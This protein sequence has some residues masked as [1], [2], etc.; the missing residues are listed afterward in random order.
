MPSTS[1]SFFS[2][3]FFPLNSIFTG[4]RRARGS[5]PDEVALIRAAA[6]AWYQ[7]GSGSQGINKP[8]TREYDITRT[9]RVY[10][11]SRYRIEAI[12]RM[13]MAKEE[14]QHQHQHQ[15]AVV[16]PDPE[17][18]MS[19][20]GPQ[21]LA[22]SDPVHAANSLLDS[23]RVQ[24]TASDTTSDYFQSSFVVD[25]GGHHHRQRN[26]CS[27]PSSSSLSSPES[28]TSSN[29]NSMSIK[30][31]E[32]RSIGLWLWRRRAVICGRSEDVVVDNSTVFRRSAHGL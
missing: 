25:V 19:N 20:S 24:T 31:E 27:L 17:I 4:R 5:A 11:P 6:W 23:Y 26:N 21:L 28:I 2:S 3:P 12:R 8:P 22:P 29:N 30:R 9:R 16:V 15:H 14:H 13:A 10:Q 18:T 1:S 7:Q 32:K